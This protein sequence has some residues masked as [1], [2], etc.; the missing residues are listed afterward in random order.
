MGNIYCCSTYKRELNATTVNIDILEEMEKLKAGKSKIDSKKIIQTERELSKIKNIERKEYSGDI[1]LSLDKNKC[2]KIASILPKREKSNLKSFKEIMKLKTDKL[3]EIE[4]AYI[5]FIWEGNNIDYDDESY[6]AGK[7]VDCTPDGAFKNGKTVCSGYSRLYK[8]IAIYLDLNVECVSCYSKGANY[9]PGDTI[10]KTNHEY[11][12]IKLNNK[13][14]PIDPTWGAGHLEETN[15]VR[16]FNDFYFLADPELLIKSHFPENEKWQ[17]TKKK[18]TLEEFL[19][20]PKIS[21]NFFKFD[22]FKFYPEEGLINLNESNLLNFKIWAKNM[23]NIGSNCNI[24]LLEKNI[25]KQKLNC[26]MINYYKD[27]L[28]F[29]CIFN[30]KGKYKVILFGNNDGGQKSHNIIEYSINV[31]NKAKIELFFPVIYSNIKEINIIEPLYN[32]IKSGEKIKFTI[33]SNLNSIII[34]DQN[35]IKLNKDKSG[36]FEKEITIKSK[37]G[38]IV[39]IAKQTGQGNYSIF[40]SY[41]VK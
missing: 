2:Q 40:A 41:K 32:N 14:Y 11:N 15:Y 20:W 38:E 26:H 7:S 31:N 35:P 29:K 13:W 23:N 16:A 30:N 12:V 21:S 37:K 28:E 18:Y 27:R 6:F 19:K 9:E 3:S 39:S 17:L 1:R 24:Y 33:M 22:F 5:L 34:L 25:Y 8:D 36:I 4:K 10:S